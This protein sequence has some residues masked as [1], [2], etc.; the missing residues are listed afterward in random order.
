MIMENIKVQPE[1]EQKWVYLKFS[2]SIGDVEVNPMIEDTDISSESYI[3][4]YQGEDTQIAC[5][6]NSNILTYTF[7]DVKS[8]E[9]NVTYT[10]SNDKEFNDNQEL[11][12][13]K[14]TLTIKPIIGLKL[15][16]ITFAIRYTD[17]NLCICSRRKE[18]LFLNLVINVVCVLQI[19]VELS[20]VFRNGNSTRCRFFSIHHCT[21]V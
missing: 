17:R 18:C 21:F 11:S 20:L 14:Q 3:I 12:L 5:S 19:K 4:P 10:K 1:F 13:D 2:K 8:G 9:K 7:T 6:I 16:E 15:C